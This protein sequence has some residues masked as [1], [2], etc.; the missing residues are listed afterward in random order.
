M[1]FSFTTL[2]EREWSDSSELLKDIM[3]AQTSYT[4]QAIAHLSE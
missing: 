3:A 2:D 4:S 1:D